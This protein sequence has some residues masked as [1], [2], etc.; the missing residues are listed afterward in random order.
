[1]KILITMKTLFLFI[2]FAVTLTV[3]G[4]SSDD[5]VNKLSSLMKIGTVT[6]KESTQ[7]SIIVEMQ[8][9]VENSTSSV[10]KNYGKQA[11]SSLTELRNLSKN[12]VYSKQLSELSKEDLKN[13][14]S[15]EDKF[16]EIT[17]IHHR[18]ESG[19]FLPYLSIK[20]GSLN[21]RIQAS[22]SGKDWIFFDKV[23][24]LSENNKYEFSI[25]DPDRK[26]GSGYV[27]EYGDDRAPIELIDYLRKVVN[28][29]SDIEMRYTGKYSFDK[30]MTKHEKSLLKDTI[31]LYDKLKK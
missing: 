21:M 22:Y 2:F 10:I 19:N 23:I 15:N 26:V 24:L 7:D 4:Q 6:T 31:D 9:L 3:K 28:S 16:K 1:M 18:K 30:K 29:E 12:I 17:F 5:E 25:N 8:K 11:I 14:K 27:G 20:K 13:F